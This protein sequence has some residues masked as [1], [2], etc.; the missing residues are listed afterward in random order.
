MLKGGIFWLLVLP[1]HNKSARLRL[2]SMESLSPV[3]VLQLFALVR[4]PIT[5]FRLQMPLQI[6][7]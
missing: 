5:V 4:K 6:W 7:C 1:L 3:L 2:L